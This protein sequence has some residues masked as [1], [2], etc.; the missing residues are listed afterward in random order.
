MCVS[1]LPPLI[2]GG[3]GLVVIGY[4]FDRKSSSLESLPGPATTMLNAVS[5]CFPLFG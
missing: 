1:A 3:D 5:F 2:G 4:L